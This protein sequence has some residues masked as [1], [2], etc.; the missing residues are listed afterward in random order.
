MLTVQ[1][2]ERRLDGDAAEPGLSSTTQLAWAAA[3]GAVYG[4]ARSRMK[5]PKVADGLVLSGLVSAVEYPTRRGPRSGQSARRAARRALIPVGAG[6]VFGYTTVAT[7]DLLA[8]ARR[9]R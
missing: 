8:G 6:T 5:L 3:V 9:T 1:S 4:V 7:F 2:L